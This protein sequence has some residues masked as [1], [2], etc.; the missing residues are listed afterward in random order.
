MRMNVI[1]EE[2]RKYRQAYQVGFRQSLKDLEQEF[3]RVRSPLLKLKTNQSIIQGLNH[4]ASALA[5]S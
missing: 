4:R 1:V 3:L 2:L 5:G